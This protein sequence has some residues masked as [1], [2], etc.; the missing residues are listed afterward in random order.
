MVKGITWYTDN[1]R[2]KRPGYYK[3]AAYTLEADMARAGMETHVIHTPWQGW[4]NTRAACRIGPRVVL[5][6]IKSGD[7]K[8]LW[9]FDADSRLLDLP[10]PVDE[11][12]DLGIVFNVL[13]GP[14]C[15][16]PNDHYRWATYAM[17]LKPTENTQR[18]LKTWMDKAEKETG[19]VGAH[20]SLLPALRES[21]CVF[22][23]VTDCLVGKLKFV[24]TANRQ[25]L[26]Q[27]PTP[28]CVT[29]V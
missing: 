27:C 7:G 16:N 15:K 26:I 25:A 2:G 24:S 8:G 3:K 4:R 28:D 20:R 6:Y 18:F 14:P 19:R 5:D 21:G 10:L 13:N 17:W 23:D 1:P 9:C 22:T 29:G 12:V 11:S